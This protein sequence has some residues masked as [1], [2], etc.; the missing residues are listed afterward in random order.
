MAGWLIS[1][2]GT[3]PDAP[4]GFRYDRAVVHASIRAGQDAAMVWLPGC[5]PRWDVS[6]DDVPANAAEGTPLYRATPKD[7]GGPEV[8]AVLPHDLVAA[9]RAVE[10]TWPRRRAA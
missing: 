5:L 4:S 9:C 7:V 10:A 6:V 3:A 2:T 8:S 1:R